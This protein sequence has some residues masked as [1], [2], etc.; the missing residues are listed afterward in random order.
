MLAKCYEHTL[1][2]ARV[3]RYRLAQG[4]ARQTKSNKEN[5]YVIKVMAMRLNRE[6]GAIPLARDSREPVDC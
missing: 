5:G 3:R 2:M 4:Q 6:G 1:V